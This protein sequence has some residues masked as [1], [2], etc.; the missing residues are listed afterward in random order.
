[1]PGVVALTVTVRH[2]YL[3]ISHLLVTQFIAEYL[4]YQF[5]NNDY[6]ET[7]EKCFEIQSNC[8]ASL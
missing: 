4:G 8:I 7:I 5:L 1:M 6:A 3:Y 2:T